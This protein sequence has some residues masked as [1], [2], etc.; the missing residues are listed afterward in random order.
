MPRTRK[1]RQRLTH[2]SYEASAQLELLPN[3]TLGSYGMY[4][5][6]FAAHRA[7]FDYYLFCEDDYVPALAHFD[8]RL[9]RM[10]SATFG[11]EEAA[12]GVLVGVLQGRP[13]E[14]RSPFNLHP[15]SSHMAS[16]AAL[17]DDWRGQ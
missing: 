1:A 11:M 8:R 7:G 4:V 15:E 6:A 17:G 10:H 3:N 9:V 2:E 12:P 13:V 5:H 16:A 14:P